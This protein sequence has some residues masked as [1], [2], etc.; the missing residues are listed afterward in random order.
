MFIGLV[1]LTMGNQDDARD[2]LQDAM[3]FCR[4]PTTVL[5]CLKQA[6]SPISPSERSVSRCPR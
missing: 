6:P 3:R 1:A 5:S 2:H 4:R